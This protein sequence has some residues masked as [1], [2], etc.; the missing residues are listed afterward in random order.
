[1]DPDTDDNIVWALP[2]L[3]EVLPRKAAIG[4]IEYLGQNTVCDVEIRWLK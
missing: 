2:S 1:M 3:Q 4:A